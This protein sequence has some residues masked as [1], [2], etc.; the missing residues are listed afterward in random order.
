MLQILQKWKERT[1][2]GMR[3]TKCRHVIGPTYQSVAHRHLCP[4]L[5]SSANNR[6]P[7]RFAV[8]SVSP[9]DA[10][11]ASRRLPNADQI[12]QFCPCLEADGRGRRAPGETMPC[13]SLRRTDKTCGLGGR[14]FRL[15]AHTAGH[16]RMLF[17][18]SATL[19]CP[20]IECTAADVLDGMP[21][22]VC[23]ARAARACVPTSSAGKEV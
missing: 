8:A 1:R 22:H 6:E 7:L 17:S 20:S 4:D 16:A 19:Q 14:H 9:P 10:Y 13:A 11:G 23:A 2:H 15:E 18:Y 21:A 3:V 12:A 5:P